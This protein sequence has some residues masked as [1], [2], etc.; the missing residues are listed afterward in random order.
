[1]TGRLHRVDLHVADLERAL[2]HPVS[3]YE[4]EAIDPHLRIHSV[5]GG[6]FRIRADGDGCVVKVVR[7]G[8]DD[9]P[10]G[11]WVSGGEPEHRNYWTREWLAFDSGLLD[12][13]PGRLRAPR[14]LL[15]TQVDDECWIWMTDVHGR[16]GATL[17]LDDYPTIAYDLGTTQGAF[18]A[19]TLP[20]DPWLSRR[21][22]RAW[23]GAC[24]RLV[25]ALRPGDALDDER[26]AALR[27]LRERVLA[28][29]ERRE[30]LLR[31]VE[32][33][34]QTLVHCDFWPANLYVS[35]DAGTVAIDW[36]QVGIGAV[37]QDLDQV[38]L[39]TVWMQV[40]PDESLDVL[41]S[42]MVPAYA[43][44]LRD[45]GLHVDDRELRRWYAAAAA[46]HY[47]WMSGMLAIRA[48]EPEFVAGLE[49]RFG[50][51]FADLVSDRARVIERSILL[52]RSALA[53]AD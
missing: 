11:L 26:L 49:Q 45:G 39:D 40:R 10:Q 36:S 21:W 7:R 14:T 38:T 42:T 19:G 20:D 1:V 31:L 41:E 50:R 29:W 27:P 15:T 25:E 51:E 46:A 17:R 32:S 48:R 35:D 33:A 30:D 6:V 8:V 37:A 22:L 52:G 4:I 18:A 12:A 13:L 23:V 43:A 5:T 2:G 28:L 47:A 9:D 24:E 3:S 34:P 44:G 16:H 53:A